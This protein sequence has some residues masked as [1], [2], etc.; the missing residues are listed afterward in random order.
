MWFGVHVLTLLCLALASLSHAFEDDLLKKLTF[1]PSGE[2]RFY[3]HLWEDDAK[4]PSC[5]WAGVPDDYTGRVEDRAVLFDCA[6]SGLIVTS[7]FK[8]AGPTMTLDFNAKDGACSDIFVGAIT[9]YDTKRNRIQTEFK[10]IVRGR[11]LQVIAHLSIRE[12]DELGFQWT[13]V[14]S[15]CKLSFVQEVMLDTQGH[16]IGMLG[17]AHNAMLDAHESVR[18]TGEAPFCSA[19]S[20]PAY[21]CAELGFGLYYSRFFAKAIAVPIG[22]DGTMPKHCGV[23]VMDV[24]GDVVPGASWG[25][26]KNW[27]LQFSGVEPLILA[28]VNDGCVLSYAVCALSFLSFRRILLR[29]WRFSMDC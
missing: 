9:H 5:T 6:R 23:A 21:Q 10:R 20:A 8:G 24:V 27:T 28:N 17:N 7:E 12:G 26:S 2:R 4:Q 22:S 14:G 29:G 15:G 18:L 11:E 3:L 19:T 25:A 1:P 16:F 13:V